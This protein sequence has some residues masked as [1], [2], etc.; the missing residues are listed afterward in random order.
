[1]PPLRWAISPSTLRYSPSSVAL[2]LASASVEPTTNERPWKNFTSERL[3]P[4]A[5]ALSR[6]S[7]MT[8]RAPLGDAALM[9]TP[10]ACLAAKARPAD[11]VPAWK[12]TGVRCGDGKLRCGPS[13]R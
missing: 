12:S 1:M 13:T 4:A 9:K 11:E 8:T 6:V 2:A 7:S 10:S 3:R 5:T